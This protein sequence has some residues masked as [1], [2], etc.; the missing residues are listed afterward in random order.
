M[1]FFGEEF[2]EVVIKCGVFIYVRVRV[3]ACDL[4]SP[5]YN[6]RNIPQTQMWLGIEPWTE[7][8]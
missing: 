4:M 6:Q 1:A 7:D 2:R 3:R 8:L 5:L